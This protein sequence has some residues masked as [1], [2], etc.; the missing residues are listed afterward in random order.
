MLKHHCLPE[1]PY[2]TRPI[3]LP[4]DLCSFQF[5]N[6]VITPKNTI[7]ISMSR[8]DY[9]PRTNLYEIDFNGKILPQLTNE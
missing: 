1:K 8:F 3:N 9:T 5:A 2:S 4:K 6:Y 7:Y